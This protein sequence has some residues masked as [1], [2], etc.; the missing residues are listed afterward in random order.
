MIVL[1][2]DEKQNYSY[3]FIHIQLHFATNHDN[4]T[5]NH[6]KLFHE[7]LYFCSRTNIKR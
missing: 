7:N 1:R 5:I 3:G 4:F 6:D 2:E